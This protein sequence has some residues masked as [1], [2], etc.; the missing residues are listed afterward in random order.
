[1]DSKKDTPSIYIDG[2]DVYE[3][4]S[5]LAKK[6][7]I[8]QLIFIMSAEINPATLDNTD[9]GPFVSSG[10]VIKLDPEALFDPTELLTVLTKQYLIN[11]PILIFEL[12]ALLINIITSQSKEFLNEEYHDEITR[13]TDELLEY[14]TEVLFTKFGYRSY[15]KKFIE[16]CGNKRKK[17]P[18]FKLTRTENHF[19][20]FGLSGED[21]NV[22]KSYLEY[23]FNLTPNDIYMHLIVQD[24]NDD[25]LH[26]LRTDK[27]SNELFTWVESKIVLKSESESKVSNISFH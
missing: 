26:L 7:T 27:D 17:D 20:G 13:D 21:Y 16:H 25:I 14:N 4:M 24:I 19:A 8:R 10:K 9:E 1:M 2:K 3:M 15:I 6:S 18:T 12:L 5:L 23:K 11:E 22:F